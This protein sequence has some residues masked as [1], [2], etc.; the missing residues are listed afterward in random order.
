M[1]YTVPDYY[2]EFQCIADRCPDTCCAGW[3]IVID[4]ESMKKYR[5]V[6]GGFKNRLHNSIDEKEQVFKQYHGRCA[7]LNDDNLCDIY[8][9]IGKEYLCR[10]CRRYPRHYEEYENI[11]EISLSVSCPVVAELLLT[12]EK[13]VTFYTMEK[14]RPE[15]EYDSFDFLLFTKL[16]D[17]RDVLIALAQNR[18]WSIEY[19]MKLLLVVAHDVENYIR[20]GELFRIDSLLD[21]ISRLLD[22][23]DLSVEFAMKRNCR[24]PK[25]W[26]SEYEDEKRA[27]ANHKKMF[28]Y[29]YQLEHLNQSWSKWLDKCFTVLYQSGEKAYGRIRD[30]WM[31]WNKKRQ[32]QAEQIL[33]YFIYTYFCGSVYDERPFSKVQTA[34]VHT[35]LFEEMQM[36]EFELDQ[37]AFSL[38]KQIEILY[39]YAREVEHSD[40]NLEAMERFMQTESVFS[41]KEQLFSANV[42]DDGRVILDRAIL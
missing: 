11:R 30:S 21:K 23:K 10:T 32:L 38:Q 37:K 6:K 9:E 12:R 14:K 33:V 39:R 3:Q 35:L 42:R 2:K 13:P 20:R 28:L 25:E 22:V 40:P 34:V 17:C 15:E 27:F 41:L 19:R 8:G 24:S 18:H 31:K 7:F 29:L 5:K 36:A 1:E 16:Q 4:K 26:F